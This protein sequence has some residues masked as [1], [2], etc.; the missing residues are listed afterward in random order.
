MVVRADERRRRERLRHQHRRRAE[1]AA[2]VGDLGPGRQLVRDP[3]ERRDPGRHQVGDV[4]RAEE[5]LAADEDVLV[6]LVPA[7]PGAGAEPL[8]DL[9]LGLQRAQRQHERARRVDRAVR[10]GQHEG[11]LLGHRKG[12]AVRVVLDVAAGR[13]AAQPLG[14]VARVGL[15]AGGELVGGCRGRCQRAVQAEPVPDHDVAR[16]RGR[17]EVGHELAEDLAELGV[18]DCHVILLQVVGVG[19]PTAGRLARAIA[20]AVAGCTAIRLQ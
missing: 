14:D 17:A 12:V 15:G 10:V 1:P 16:R 9:R 7:Q 4:A 20:R 3:V 5:L 8:G 18:V 11:L 19:S 2:E 6:V 13:L